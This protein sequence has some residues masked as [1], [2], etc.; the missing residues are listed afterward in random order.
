MEY[1]NIVV[2]VGQIWHNPM[3]SEE[4]Y[5]IVEI[6]EE[7]SLNFNGDRFTAR[8]AYAAKYI[9]GVLV[10]TSRC[11]GPLNAN[12]NPLH[13]SIGWKLLKDNPIKNKK[14]SRINRNTLRKRLRQQIA[15]SSLT[16]KS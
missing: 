6:V 4:R 11:F 8:N 9:G 5:E 2:E 12:N 15:A 3:W 10:Y 13:W 7:T 1:D 16:E 14:Y